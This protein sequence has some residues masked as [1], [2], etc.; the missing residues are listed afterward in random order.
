[1]SLSLLQ[2]IAIRQNTCTCTGSIFQHK[3]VQLAPFLSS[4]TPDPEALSKAITIEGYKYENLLGR[5]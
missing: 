4:L 2:R 5:L 1:M 3:Y